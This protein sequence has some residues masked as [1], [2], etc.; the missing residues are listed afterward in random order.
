MNMFLSHL[1]TSH[2]RSRNFWCVSVLLEFEPFRH[3]CPTKP[4]L[5]VVWRAFDHKAKALV[6]IVSFVSRLCW[7]WIWRCH[8][9]SPDVTMF[10]FHFP[11]KEPFS[12]LQGLALRPHGGLDSEGVLDSL[13]KQ[14]R[15]LWSSIRRLG[16]AL[17]RHDDITSSHGISLIVMPVSTWFI[18][19]KKHLS[20]PY[21]WTRFRTDIYT[22][23]QRTYV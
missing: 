5:N 21:S 8:H 16:A 20:L 10:Y 11:K 19:S 13:V 1:I 23:H 9:V 15:V 17:E 4:E 3:R 14:T 22:P 12:W 2:L 6:W 18:A 7:F